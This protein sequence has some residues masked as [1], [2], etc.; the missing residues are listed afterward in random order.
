MSEPPEG[1]KD[2]LEWAKLCAGPPAAGADG[3]D[4]WQERN[5]EKLQLD[6]PAKEL[7]WKKSGN[8]GIL[9]EIGTQV[10]PSWQPP[11]PTP[12]QPQPPA[13][14]QTPTTV[15]AINATSHTEL[16]AAFDSGAMVTSIG[17]GLIEVPLDE[18]SQAVEI[19][20]A[21]SELH[22]A[23]E[24]LDKSEAANFS[25]RDL[26]T[27]QTEELK[28]AQ[29]ELDKLATVATINKE[30]ESK[31][32]ALMCELVRAQQHIKTITA[33]YDAV[34][35][36]A[37]RLGRDKNALDKWSRFLQKHGG[38]VKLTVPVPL[39]FDNDYVTSSKAAKNMGALP[40]TQQE[41]R[42]MVPAGKH[43]RPFAKWLLM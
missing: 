38:M 37:D 42:W 9:K 11:P 29:V 31:N 3:W 27:E 16:T 6:V 36:Q 25:L 32:A 4:A 40:P 5:A 39:I 12:S 20:L 22:D 30:L 41:A 17:A 19:M 33:G 43:V 15:V 13:T 23:T 28:A 10:G 14:P 2:E 7:D 8:R 18:T 26:L 1:I 21:R 34:K 24:E 35:K